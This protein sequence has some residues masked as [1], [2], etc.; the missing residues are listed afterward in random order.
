M[1]QNSYLSCFPRRNV[2]L[3]VGTNSLSSGGQSLTVSAANVHAQYNSATIKND[4]GT[5]ITSSNIVLNNLVRPV[6]LSFENVGGGVQSRVAGWG[7]TSV[8]ATM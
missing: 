2:R 6:S 1:D 4:I 3:N 8:S 5:L 7:R